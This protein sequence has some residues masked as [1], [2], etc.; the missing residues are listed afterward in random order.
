MPAGGADVP[1]DAFADDD[2]DPGR[3]ARVFGID[4]DA[5]F[6]AWGEPGELG[7]VRLGVVASARAT[8]DGDGS[9]PRT[10]PNC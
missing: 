7:A 8:R 5:V 4:L 10:K 6:R 9:S 1:V 2:A 3:A